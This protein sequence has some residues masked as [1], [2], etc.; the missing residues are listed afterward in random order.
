MSGFEHLLTLVSF[1]LALSMTTILK[2]VAAL[3]RRRAAARL[4][5]PHALWTATIFFNQIAFWLGAYNFSAMTTATYVIIAFVIG[6]P[7]LLFL[8]SGLV[9]AGDDGPIDLRAHHASNGRAYMGLCLAAAA[10]ETLFMAAMAPHNGGADLATYFV[11][12]G[13][14]AAATL[15]AMIF[16]AGA[17]QVGAPAL[18]LGITL[19]NIYYGSETLVGAR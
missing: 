12:Q 2:F 4:S 1:V 8:Q 11:V 13:L 7:V 19:I 3:Y 14:A 6:Q 16:R 15:A 5:A 17:V 18:V 10:S 9:V